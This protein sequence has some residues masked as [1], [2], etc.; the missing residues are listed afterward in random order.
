MTRIVA[1]AERVPAAH[2]TV[3]GVAAAVTATAPAASWW[4]TAPAEPA[5]PLGAVS[6]GV[7]GADVGGACTV[8]DAD[9]LVLP[10]ELVAVTISVCPPT[11]RPEAV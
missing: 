4:M 2:W 7:D 3:T 9:L 10:M 8:Q 11:V 6:G 1:S 5:G